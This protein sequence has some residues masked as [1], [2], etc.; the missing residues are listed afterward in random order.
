MRVRMTLERRTEKFR[1]LIDRPC[2]LPYND[3]M[4]SRR[5]KTGALVSCAGIALNFLL[6]AAKI[7]VGLLFGL[8]SVVADGLNNLSDCGSG[9]TALVSF[10]ISDKP[11]DKE[12]PFGHR[13]AEY[14]AAMVTGFLILF[15]AAETLRESVVRI[16][17]G[18]SPS[19]SLT[20]ILL[21]IGSVLLK[22][23]MFALYRVFGARLGS[24]ALKAAA[25]DS[26]C[27]C[28]ATVA[29]LAGIGLSR[30]GLAA[31]GW[32]GV[33]VAV[34]IGWQGIKILKEASSELLGHAPD[35]K[36]TAEIGRI[37]AGTDGVLGFHDLQIYSYG[38][39]VSFATVHAEMDAAIPA[40]DAHAVIDGIETE[41]REKTGVA[42]TVH[43]DPVNLQDKE[44]ERLA[45][46]VRRAAGEAIEG[47]EVHDFR[48]IAGKR[49]AFDAG[50]P[51][52]CK[53]SDEEVRERLS[54]IVRSLGDYET[55][56]RVERE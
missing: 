46:A 22:A 1:I 28:F 53:L 6:A 9:V 33:I 56:V 12:H 43:P 15:M 32:A 10:Y 5:T 39:G 36:L 45:A 42:L 25:T 4:K 19:G 14:L 7:A 27:D 26:L 50:V 21:L 11:A 41:V 8:V 49:A 37:I 29:V 3:G 44:A 35:P 24:D 51:Y 13:R 47:I 23:G 30:L 54:A 52:A 31:D 40:L 20:A 18:T 2:D 48:L 55:S 34:F 38:R 16:A 17:A